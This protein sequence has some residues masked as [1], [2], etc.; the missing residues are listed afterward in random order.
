MADYG[1]LRQLKNLGAATVNILHA[2]GV[3]TYD[4]LKALGSV[5]TYLR[6]KRRG[7]SVS[8]VMLYALEGALLDV[9]WKSLD[10]EVKAQLVEQA[11]RQPEQP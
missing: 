7:I 5:E 9:H 6:I 10:P 3:T 2:V 1:D 11:E 4:D 8:K